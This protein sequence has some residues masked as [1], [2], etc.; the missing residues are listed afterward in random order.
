M[1]RLTLAVLAAVL[2]L[3][4]PAGAAADPLVVFLVRHAE[5]ADSSEDPQLTAVGRERAAELARVLRDAHIEHVHSSDYIRTR[6]TA[7]PVAELARA[8]VQLYD[9]RD[10]P[11]LV[12][13]MKRAGGRHLVVGHS[14]T[15]PDLVTLLGGEPGAPIVESDEYDRLYTVAVGK[16]GTVT[17]LM[18][19]Y[20]RP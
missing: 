1:T 15:T 19:R 14:N 17:S 8:E 18:L 20:G 9:P 10:L 3:G 12:E 4:C 5:K 7:T 13:K 16:D 2:A 6:D 11:A